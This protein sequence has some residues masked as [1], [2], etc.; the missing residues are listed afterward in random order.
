VLQVMGYVVNGT[1]GL[2]GIWRFG[3]HRL[4]DLRRRTVDDPA[5]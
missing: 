5:A 3:F 2:I 4:G 1:L